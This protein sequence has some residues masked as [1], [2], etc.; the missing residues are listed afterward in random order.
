M[1]ANITQATFSAQPNSDWL[2]QWNSHMASA[3]QTT[4]VPHE[5]T[6]ITTPLNV[7][8]WS[9]LLD[10][11]P[12]KSPVGFFIAGISSGFRIGFNR[13]STVL[14]SSRRNLNCALEHPDV[15]DR[16]L[17]EQLSYRRL[18][19]PFKPLDIPNAHISRFGVIPK[20]HQPNKWRLIVDLSHPS[21]QS[22]NDGISKDI[23]S[24]T[25]ITVDTA[26]EQIMALGKGTLLAKTDI[27]S[28]FRLLPV[29]PADRHLLA[30][31]WRQQ[32]YID[33]CLPFGLRSAPK[34]FNVLAD[35]LTWI[36]EQ[37]GVQPIMHY[38]DDFLTLGPP[39]SPICSHNLNT[40]TEVCQKL[41]VPLALEKVEGPSQTLTFLGIVLDT[42]HMEAR[43]PHEK[44]QR[45]RNQLTSWLHK[46][47]ATK[48][49]ILSLVELLQ[50]ATKVV[51]PGRTFVARMYAAAAR[52]K[53]LH[54]ITRLNKAF[55]S[56]LYWWH[57]FVTNWNG[58][59]F[60]NSSLSQDHLSFEFHIQTD[61]S[62]H[63]G[64]G[65]CFVHQWLQ[66]PWSEEWR[67]VS[68]MA[69]EL[70]PIVLSCAVWGTSLSRSRV[71]FQCD[72]LILVEVINKGSSKDVMVM[73]L[74]RC[75]WFFQAF[76]NLNI[77]ASHIPGVLN[78]APDMISRNQ[79]EKFLLMYPQYYYE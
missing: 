79:T 75:L 31:K 50:H 13:P 43:L 35:L 6:Y 63:W 74:L 39:D 16:Y 70:V 8:H 52:L 22:V 38:L 56:D 4:K 3:D 18:A 26:I 67:D 21:G 54:H 25:Y 42:K 15:V 51:K 46:R 28:A 78:T 65:A 68:I 76:F 19:G 44:L 23:C 12:D 48:R 11:H 20:N 40:I 33:T 29:H 41:G 57:L 10:V 27:K 58:V 37:N 36:L 30:M 77:V 61:A 55:K 47:K 24:L 71:K 66:Q 45:I 5:A 49:Q 1:M 60:I 53:Q 9:A 62:G 7:R 69:K 64:C 14:S 34:L 73:H 72:N 59:S 17:T 32:L 2:C